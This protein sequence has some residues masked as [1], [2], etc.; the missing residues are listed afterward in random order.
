MRI[1]RLLVLLVL[2]GSL[3]IAAGADAIVAGDVVRFSDL[4]G[5]HRRR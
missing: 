1:V 2:F 5:Q 3:P 4:A